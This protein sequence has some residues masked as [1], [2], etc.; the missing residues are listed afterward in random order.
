V[1]DATVAPFKYAELL[2]DLATLGWRPS[3][4]GGFAAP[5]RE[6]L[7]AFG[8]AEQLATAPLAAAVAHLGR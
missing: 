4:I 3:K 5:P 2:A 7:E 6:E 1:I 8:L